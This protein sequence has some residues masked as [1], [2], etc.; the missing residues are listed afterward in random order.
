VV[1]LAVALA[2]VAL[3]LLAAVMLGH[4]AD[5]SGKSGTPSS[6]PLPSQEH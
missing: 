2:A 1:L 5:R 4:L 6:A 3:V